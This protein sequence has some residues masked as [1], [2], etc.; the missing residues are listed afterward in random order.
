MTKVNERRPP[1]GYSFEI[2]HSVFDIRYFLRGRCVWFPQFQAGRSR[3]CGL[4]SLLLRASGPRE[5]GNTLLPQALELVMQASEADSQEFGRP[6]PIS[7]NA[8][9][10][11]QDE[12]SLGIPQ[13][14]GP[15]V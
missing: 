12:V 7:L 14:A 1:K 3:I 11:L 5:L 2:R 9:E 15:G 4:P 8:L 6:G 13:A 10:R